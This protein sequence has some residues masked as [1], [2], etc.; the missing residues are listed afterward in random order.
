MGKRSFGLSWMKN[1]INQ[2]H[3]PQT[4]IN[5]KSVDKRSHQPHAGIDARKV[6]MDAMNIVLN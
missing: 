1:D 6:Q 5:T 2:D 4:P 3:S